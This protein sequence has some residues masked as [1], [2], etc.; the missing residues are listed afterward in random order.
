MFV[1]MFESL[2]SRQL[3]AS[4]VA[5]SN[6]VLTITGTGGNDNIYVSTSI[7]NT[8]RVADQNVQI[9]SLIPKASV[10]KIVVNCGAGNDFAY[11]NLFEKVPT[12]ID[13]GAGND[14]LTA[15]TAGNN[16]VLGGLGDDNLVGGSANDSID[17]GDGKDVLSGGVGNDT[18]LG[19]SGDDLLTGGTGNDLLDG[20]LGA[21]K[22][23]GSEGADTVTYASR[24]NPIV[25]DITDGATELPDDGEA[26]EKDFIEASVENLIGGKGND[27]LTGSTYAGT[28]TGYTK[29]NKL[30]G[31]GGNDSLFG[32]DGNDIID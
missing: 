6:G 3:L 10:K 30:V 20:G 18:L 7:G 2:E 25:A 28:P 1:P 13:G 19:G 12:L 11:V 26:G 31:G 4:T 23:R 5:L 9:G 24:T 21:D 32:L 27:K 17:G 14:G 16:T 22:L 29:N 15:A 8:I